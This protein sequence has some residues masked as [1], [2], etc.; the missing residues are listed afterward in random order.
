MPIAEFPLPS[1]SSNN[2]TPSVVYQLPERFQV[3]STEYDDGGRDVKLQNGGNGIK[4]WALAYTVLS[5]TAAAI[6]DAHALAAKLGEDGPSANTFNFRDPTDGTLYAGCRYLQYDRPAHRRR[7]IQ[8]RN[9]VI[10]K[11]P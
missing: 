7:H 3:D 11:Y 4:S 9:I 6:L 1:V 5:T 8:S 2:P 10:I